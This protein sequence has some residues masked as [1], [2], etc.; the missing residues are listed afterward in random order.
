MA[1]LEVD[2]TDY[3]K[4]HHSAG[5]CHSYSRS[6][7]SPSLTAAAKWQE[8]GFNSEEECYRIHGYDGGS[9]STEDFRRYDYWCG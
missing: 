2:P 8:R 6:P 5:R 3:L 7:A 1:P 9:I 4:V